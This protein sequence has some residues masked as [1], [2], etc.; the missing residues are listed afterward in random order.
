MDLEKKVSEIVGYYN[1]KELALSH[2]RYEYLQTLNARQFGELVTKCNTE[3]LR[4][5]DVV[6]EMA[7]KNLR[8]MVFHG[9]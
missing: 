3:C 9:V 5:D 4:F 1:E 2:I 7:L 6:L 8:L